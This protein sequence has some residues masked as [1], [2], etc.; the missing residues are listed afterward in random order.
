M[1]SQR[2]YADDV[3][4]LVGDQDFLPGSP[5]RDV[6]LRTEGAVIDLQVLLL[7]ACSS[8]ARASERCEEA[9]T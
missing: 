6:F 8:N 2:T 4:R 5:L 7:A 1:C 3:G 9:K